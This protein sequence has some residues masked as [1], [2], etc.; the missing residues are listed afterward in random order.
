MK[1]YI[2]NTDS[3]DL[4]IAGIDSIW[5][6]PESASKA[7]EAQNKEYADILNAWF[8]EYEVKSKKDLEGYMNELDSSSRALL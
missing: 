8:G 7:T 3:D 6:N 2:V 4:H 5:D 1:V